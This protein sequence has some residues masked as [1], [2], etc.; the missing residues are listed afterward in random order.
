MPKNIQQTIG[1][2]GVKPKITKDPGIANYIKM[3][4]VPIV[5]ITKVEGKCTSTCVLT[6]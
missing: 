5:G 1:K 3:V 6:V 4:H 2:I